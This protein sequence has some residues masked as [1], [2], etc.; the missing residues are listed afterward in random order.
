MSTT[1]DQMNSNRSTVLLHAGEPNQIIP[2]GAVGHNPQSG[3]NPN[4]KS[5]FR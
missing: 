1:V 2:P 5:L 3:L 4:G